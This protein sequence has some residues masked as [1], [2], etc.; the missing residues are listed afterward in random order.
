MQKLRAKFV[1]IAVGASSGM[2]GL[3]SLSKCSGSVCTSCFG[4][5][6]AGIGILLITL[7]SKFKTVKNEAVN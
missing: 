1:S 2:A 3:L 5:A 6:G 7:Y 4:C